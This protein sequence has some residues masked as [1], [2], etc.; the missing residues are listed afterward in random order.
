M[1]LLRRSSPAQVDEEFL[2]ANHVA[3]HNEYKVV[4]ALRFLGLI[5][6]QGRPTEKSRLLKTRGGPFALN[7]QNIVREAYA[8]LFARV[9]VREA[10]ADEIH[11][12][13]VTEV[14]LGA[15]M[16]NKATRF[17]VELCKMADLEVGTG[18][19]KAPA[20]RQS[21]SVDGRGL[22]G[23]PLEDLGGVALP[24]AAGSFPL[25]VTIVSG[26]A[27]P[28]MLAITPEVAQMSEDELVRLLQK[29]QRAARR[30]LLE[31]D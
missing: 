5:D 17:F 22:G 2:K 13:F 24:R 10:T 14:G 16:A 21:P 1:D 19:R 12:Y 9:R 30:A 28:V 25:G 15:E 29:L 31:G 8:D 4:G 26:P 20:A 6:E 18:E 7:L 23:R 27:F 11:N 3:P